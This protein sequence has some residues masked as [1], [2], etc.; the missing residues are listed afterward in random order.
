YTL[1]TDRTARE[2]A[3]RR[4]GDPQALLA[5]RGM[6]DSRVRAFGD[7]LLALIRDAV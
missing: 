2:L 1:F 4:P 7:E 6:G 5:V 3:A